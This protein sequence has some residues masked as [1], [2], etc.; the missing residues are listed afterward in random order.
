MVEFG[1]VSFFQFLSGHLDIPL[2]TRSLVLGLKNISS[3]KN[4]V[5]VKTKIILVE[6]IKKLNLLYLSFIE[7]MATKKYTMFA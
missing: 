4:E 5:I 2:L 6:R 3:L 7:C 1:R